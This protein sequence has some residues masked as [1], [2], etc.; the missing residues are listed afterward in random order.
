MCNERQIFDFYSR[1]ESGIEFKGYKQPWCVKA[2]TDDNGT[3]YSCNYQGI[4]KVATDPYRASQL[5]QLIFIDRLSDCKCTLEVTVNATFVLPREQEAQVRLND[6]I[7][8]LVEAR[9]PPNTNFKFGEGESIH[10][11]EH[12]VPA[13]I[14]G[15]IKWQKSGICIQDACG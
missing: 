4:G 7:G 1:D 14:A 2:G 15:K 10:T 12:T 6:G 13:C 5:C 3:E 8:F 9:S 11:S